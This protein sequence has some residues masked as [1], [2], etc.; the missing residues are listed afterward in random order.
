MYCHYCGTRLEDDARFCH[1]CG[2][3][4]SSV[5]EIETV[6]WQQPVKKKTYLWIIPVSLI[7]LALVILAIIF[8]L[9]FW[10][11]SDKNPAD[12]VENAVTA[13]TEYSTEVSGKN[14]EDEEIFEQLPLEFTFC[15][16]VGNWATELTLWEDGSFYGLYYDMNMGVTGNDYPNGTIYI[17]NFRGEF[18]NLK[19]INEYIYSMKVTN[20]EQDEPNFTVYYEDD[21]RYIVTEPYGFDDADEFLIYLPGCPVED[22]EEGFAVWPFI[23][24]DDTDVMPDGTYGIY[25]VNGMHGFWGYDE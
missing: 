20:L 18:T 10:K 9:K 11:I 6:T 13:E 1:H 7:F 17:C 2:S 5:S 24:T 16:G 4:V 12:W 21:I 22:M 19:K 14:T 25:N 8:V 15:S 23:D 3:L